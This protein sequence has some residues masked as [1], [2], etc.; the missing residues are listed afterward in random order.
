[1]EWGQGKKIIGGICRFFLEKGAKGGQ[2][3]EEKAG[4][5]GIFSAVNQVAGA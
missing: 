3:L 2:K 1:M 5:F 4:S